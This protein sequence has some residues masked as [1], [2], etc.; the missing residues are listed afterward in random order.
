MD[1]VPSKDKMV[2]QTFKYRIKETIDTYHNLTTKVLHGTR[3]RHAI[4]PL[5]EVGFEP[6][7]MEK[8]NLFELEK[9][10]KKT[11]KIGVA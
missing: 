4:D 11:A 1:A 9:L 3:I 7:P 10:I 5:K 8:K 2:K 6:S